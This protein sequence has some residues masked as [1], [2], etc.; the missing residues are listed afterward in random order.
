MPANLTPELY[1]TIATTLLT[2]LLWMPHILQRIIELKPIEAFRDP[3]H[4][5]DTKAPWAQRAI[6]AHTNAVENL[7]VFGLL[8]LAVHVLGA[9]TA[10]TAMAA[11]IF[12][13][14]RAAHYV[15]YVLG[16]PW[17]RT[18]MFLIGFACQMVLGLTLLGYL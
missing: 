2:S 18:P 1:W 10:L 4:D 7:V 13:V 6:R 15:F 9:G 8:A 11:F 14:A 3:R 17:L 5:V 12:F 16:V